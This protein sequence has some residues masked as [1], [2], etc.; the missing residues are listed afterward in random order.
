M[1]PG[2]IG[3]SQPEHHW[4]CHYVLVWANTSPNCLSQFESN[5]ILFAAKVIR[6]DITPLTQRK[7]DVS[8]MT[9][10]P[11]LPT[12]L[13]K[14]FFPPTWGPE[15]PNQGTSTSLLLNQRLSALG[16]C[17]LD[18]VSLVFKAMRSE[19]QKCHMFCRMKKVIHHWNSKWNRHAQG[20]RY[21]KSER[22][23]GINVFCSNCFRDP[24]TSLPSPQLDWSALSRMLEANKL[25]FF[26][27]SLF[28]VGFYNFVCIEIFKMC[29]ASY[30]L[31]LSSLN[32]QDEAHLSPWFY[33]F[34]ATLTP[35]T[36]S[37][38]PLSPK[39]GTLSQLCNS[40]PLTP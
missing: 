9:M 5:F 25:S 36:F 30:P 21:G 35:G 6:T 39:P 8:Q 33:S 37:S 1:D 13:C 24:A 38:I 17:P 12:P 26:C 16:M 19:T 4:T 20:A 2:A 23:A 22:K 29:S 18:S 15:D 31:I 10:F 40:W 3:V 34:P 28:E 32:I 14:L 27:L 7:L 11:I